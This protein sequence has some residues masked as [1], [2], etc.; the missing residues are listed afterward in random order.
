MSGHS[1]LLLCRYVTC[2]CPFIFETL[3]GVD[4][5]NVLSRLLVSQA[6]LEALAFSLILA[7]HGSQKLFGGQ[8]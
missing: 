2:R 4:M 1:K 8:R 3:Y 5:K 6:G 7:A